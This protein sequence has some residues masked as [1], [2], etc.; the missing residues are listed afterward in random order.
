MTLDMN[1]TVIS[2]TPR[3]N[4]MKTIEANLITGSCERRP[5]A[6]QD[7]DRQRGDHADDGNHQGHQQ[8]APELGLDIGEA[9]IEGQHAT[10]RQQADDDPPHGPQCV[11]PP[12]RSAWCKSPAMPRHRG[13]ERG[14]HR[15]RA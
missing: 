15:S 5:S 10:T 2:G 1:S 3:Q 11:P 14:E 13:D 8:A 12:G 4:S 6:K 9:E 7:A